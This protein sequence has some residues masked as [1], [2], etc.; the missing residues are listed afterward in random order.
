M[1]LVEAPANMR[2]LGNVSPGTAI[3]YKREYWLVTEGEPEGLINLVSLKTGNHHY[4]KPTV[5]VEVFYP[6]VVFS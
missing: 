5:D 2:I 6:K 1:Y 3:R 4:V